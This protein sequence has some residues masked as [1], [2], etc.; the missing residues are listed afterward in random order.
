M[1]QNL[2]KFNVNVVNDIATTEI[3]LGDTLKKLN[4]N[5]RNIA[6]VSILGPS[7][8]GKSAF[9]NCVLSFLHKKDVHAFTSQSVKLAEGK[10]VTTGMN[11][12]VQPMKGT[13]DYMF[14]DVQGLGGVHSEQDPSVLMFCYYISDLII[15]NWAQLV[16]SSALQMLMPIAALTAKLKT[17]TTKRPYIMFRVLDAV[18]DYDDDLAKKNFSVMMEKRKDQING[19]RESIRELFIIPDKPVIW[20][21]QP[22]KATKLKF[23]KGDFSDVLNIKDDYHFVAACSSVFDI[24]QKIKGNNKVISDIKQH[25]AEIN[26][27]N[28]I[29]NPVI[30]DTSSR[31]NKEDIETWINGTTIEND[32]EE[33]LPSQIPEELKIPLNITSAN[34][35][36]YEL[37]M[38]RR[39][40]IDTV[41][42]S[43]EK[44]FGKAPPDVRNKGLLTI[45]SMLEKH[46]ETAY[47]KCKEHAYNTLASLHKSCEP[48]I[49]GFDFASAFLSTNIKQVD[50]YF[51]QLDKLIKESNL[52]QYWKIEL[53]KICVNDKNTIIKHLTR[54]NDEFVKKF[55]IERNSKYNDA[56]LYIVNL[57]ATLNT[58]YEKIE[59]RFSDIIEAVVNEFEEKFSFVNKSKKQSWISK[60]ANL[61]YSQ[62]EK[63]YGIPTTSTVYRCTL[64]G[65]NL[66]FVQQPSITVQE[67]STAKKDIE[68][69]MT[70]LHKKLNDLEKTFCQRRLVN[71][72]ELVDRFTD[73]KWVS[74][75]KTGDYSGFKTKLIEKFN[76]LKHYKLY[77]LP[78]K[79]DSSDQ[80]LRQDYPHI[81]YRI[82]TE[83]LYNKVLP[84]CT[85]KYL[86]KAKD[87]Q[88]YDVYVT[89]AFQLLTDYLVIEL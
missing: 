41:Y 34:E 11:Y 15:V 78:I 8:K 37:C 19:V 33:K 54:Y 77:L 58:Y 14:I 55:N 30:F 59:L 9:L 83:D 13:T 42:N 2:A 84:R 70:N 1:A 21:E 80:I 49:M 75:I 27:Q 60:F 28:S 62:E 89:R 31:I 3:I 68:T 4:D 43:Y 73:Y 81:I 87:N 40:A 56:N 39:N 26:G 25:V 46:Y 65:K 44:R 71:L 79:E 6:V 36:M 32:G 52:A 51:T 12:Y 86:E 88:L 57:Q 35:P 23:D 85:R 69:L 61:F 45:K 29:I 47:E 22:D 24:L 16:D 20:T 72:Q 67:T 82:Y 74:Q 10:D 76:Q 17:K 5:S 18:D 53:Y 7:R 66:T 38:A 64:G 63:S 48:S 50:A